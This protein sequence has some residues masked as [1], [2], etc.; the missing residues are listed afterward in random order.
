MGTAATVDDFLQPGVEQVCAGFALY[1]PATMLVLTTG[2]GVDGFTLD[3]DIGAFLL[4]HPQLRIPSTTNEFA[5]NSSNERFWEPPVMDRPSPPLPDRT[6]PSGDRPPTMFP[7]VLSRRSP[8][9]A[10]PRGLFP[11]ASVP[12]RT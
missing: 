2:D 11:A 7:K 12:I 1:G 10:L 8:F 6:L 4:T 9:P 5:I 3:R